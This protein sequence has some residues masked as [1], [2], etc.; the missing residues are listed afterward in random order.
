MTRTL[1]LWLKSAHGCGS[2]ENSF[3]FKF[4]EMGPALESSG[5]PTNIGTPES[6]SREEAPARVRCSAVLAYLDAEVLTEKSLLWRNFKVN[7]FIGS[8]AHVVRA[9]CGAS[10]VSGSGAASTRRNKHIYGALAAWRRETNWKL[11]IRQV[12]R[13]REQNW[14]GEGG[15]MAKLNASP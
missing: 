13:G 15:E 12:L 8:R 14:L 6:T 7:K 10:A 11:S 9:V 3:V 2:H 1:H 5:G 4:L